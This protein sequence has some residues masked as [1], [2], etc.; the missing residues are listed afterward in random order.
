MELF[1][2]FNGNGSSSSHFFRDMQL[3]S[4]L[5]H[6]STRSL[7]NILSEY[8]SSSFLLEFGN[9]LRTYCLGPYLPMIFCLDLD[10][11]YLYETDKLI[12]F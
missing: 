7:F 10:L 12:Y 3:S 6:S 8:R 9:F 1:G 2:H 11:Y 5:D 4:L